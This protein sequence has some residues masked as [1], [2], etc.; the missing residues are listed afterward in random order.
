MCEHD[1]L[2]RPRG[3]RRVHDDG[4]VVGGGGHGGEVAC[5]LGGALAHQLAEGQDLDVLPVK[6]RKKRGI[7]ILVS[8]KIN[9][10]LHTSA[11][12]I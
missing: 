4:G 11:E 9:N 3:P 7:R 1:P 6:G 12:P 5:G 8:L 10:V 2:G